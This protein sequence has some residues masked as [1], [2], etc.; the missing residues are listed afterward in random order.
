MKFGFDLFS[1]NY[2]ASPDLEFMEKEISS[3]ENVWNTKEKWDV[4]YRQFCTIKF[5]EVNDE[6]L[7]EEA[8]EYIKN[9]NAY[10][11]EMKKWEIVNYIRAN[12]D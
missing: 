6:E 10:T 9:L 1:I 12:I 8:E 7:D 3:L 11:K 5:N 4:K 2:S